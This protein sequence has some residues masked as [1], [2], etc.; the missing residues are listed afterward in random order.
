MKIEID[1]KTKQ[2]IKYGVLIAVALIALLIYGIVRNQQ[3][4]SKILSAEAIESVEN[5]E[6]KEN[7][8]NGSMRV[9]VAGAVVNPGVYTLQG[10]ARVIDAVEAAGGMTEDGN[11]DAMNLAAPISDGEKITV[12]T[13]DE[14]AASTLGAGG[15]IASG[16]ININTAS[17][18]ELMSLPGIGEVIA[19]NIITYREKNGG[20]GRKEEI[21]E[22]NRIGDKIYKEIEDLITI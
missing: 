1:H 12:Y 9:H 4:Q 17:K 6:K 2:R 22:V 21:K 20:F 8:N 5:D 18:E 15:T 14:V 19:G 13:Y 7:K 3:Q 11:G 10:D 16:L